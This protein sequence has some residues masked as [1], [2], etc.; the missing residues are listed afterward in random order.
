MSLPVGGAVQSKDVS[1]LESW[2]WHQRVTLWA[3]AWSRAG[4]YVPT[5][6]ALTVAATNCGETRV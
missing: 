3:G 1:Q 5:G 2:P 4:D 6:L